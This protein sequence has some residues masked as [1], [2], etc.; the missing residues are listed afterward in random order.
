MQCGGCNWTLLNKS[1]WDQFTYDNSVTTEEDI[2]FEMYQLPLSF[3]VPLLLLYGL[4]VVISFGGN[5]VVCY[6]ICDVKGLH[7]VTNFFIAN[8]AVSDILMTVL[9]IPTTVLSDIIYKHWVLGSFMCPVLHYIQLVVVMQRAFAM[10]A[11]TCDR[12][13]LISKPLKRRMT[14]PTARLLVLLLWIAAFVIALPTG[15][16][17]QVHYLQ[18]EPGSQGLCIEIWETHRLR[19]VY[20]III[21]LLQYVI[22][23][24]IMICAYIHI[25]YMIWIKPTPGEANKERDKRIALSKRKVSL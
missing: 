15:M 4:V 23:L 20:S 25:G 7:T 19:N 13:C 21:Q 10:V 2:R 22:P 8:L 12:H 16:V 3:I 9:C 14:K 24:I 11:I 5:I 6:T 17:S 18:Y 1:F